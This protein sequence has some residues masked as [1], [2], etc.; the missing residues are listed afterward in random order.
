M[1]C[2]LWKLLLAWRGQSSVQGTEQELKLQKLITDVEE[3]NFV[4]VGLLYAE[5]PNTCTYLLWIIACLHRQSLYRKHRKH[6]HRFQ[7]LFFLLVSPLPLREVSKR[8]VTRMGTA[9]SQH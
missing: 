4:K 8:K 9:D 3:L 6:R 7:L 5:S 2:K 1:D